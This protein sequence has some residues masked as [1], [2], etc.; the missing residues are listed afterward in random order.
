[1]NLKRLWTCTGLLKWHTFV[2][3]KTWKMWTQKICQSNVK[4][5][6]KTKHHQMKNLLVKCIETFLIYMF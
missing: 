3:Y 4:I 5:K 2:T 1:M 6:I